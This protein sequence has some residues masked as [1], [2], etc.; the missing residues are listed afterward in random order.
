MPLNNR[1]K[2]T[3]AIGKAGYLRQIGTDIYYRPENKE[4]RE[5]KGNNPDISSDQSERGK[6]RFQMFY[7]K[8]RH[9]YKK[10]EEKEKKK[11]IEPS[12]NPNS[13]P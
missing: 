9:F 12:P 4:E 13:S 5:K 8:P 3:T 2:Y 7:L 11:E 1:H 10:K 6:N